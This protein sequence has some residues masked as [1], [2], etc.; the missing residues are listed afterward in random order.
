M[1]RRYCLTYIYHDCFLL[2]TEQAVIIFDFWKDPLSLGKDKDFPPLLDELNKEKPIYL[3]VSHHHKD[4][5][6]RR[7]FLWEKWFP[8]IKYIISPDIMKA[9]RY[10][11]TESTYSGYKPKRENVT[12][13]REGETFRDD[14]I[15]VRAFGSTDIGNSYTI[16]IDD[17]KVFHAGDLN[18]WLQNQENDKVAFAKIVNNIA[19]RYPRIDIAMFP[20]D[21][22]IGEEY[23]WGAK[24][25][26]DRILTAL[27]IPM[28]FELVLTPKEKEQRRLDAAAFNLFAR[29]DYGT[30]LQLAITRSRYIGF[31]D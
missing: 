3:L 24:Y 10:M 29:S 2:E 27:F 6:T 7:I 20:L 12:V 8:D 23:W 14:I 5:F 31:Y 1:A 22:R 11:M 13:L 25:F 19:H 18:A 17:L 21:S 30:Y 15:K 26:V 28:H 4:H 9:V 16:E